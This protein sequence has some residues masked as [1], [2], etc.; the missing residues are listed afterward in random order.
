MPQTRLA[1]AVWEIP[2]PLAVLFVHLYASQDARL[3]V[4]LD[5]LTP[6]LQEDEHRISAASERRDEGTV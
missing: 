4:V 6:A 2:P 5:H 3:T 1:R